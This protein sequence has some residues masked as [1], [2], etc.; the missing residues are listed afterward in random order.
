VA[1]RACLNGRSSRFRPAQPMSVVHGQKLGVNPPG[2]MANGP[3]TMHAHPS[4]VNHTSSPPFLHLQSTVS[5]TPVALLPTS[6]RPSH[7]FCQFL[8]FEAPARAR[9]ASSSPLTLSLLSLDPGGHSLHTDYQCTPAPAS[10][11]QVTR[12][13]V[14]LLALTTFNRPV[15]ITTN[16]FDRSL[17]PFC[18]SGRWSQHTPHQPIWNLHSR[19]PHYRICPLL[20]KADTSHCIFVK[21]TPG[22]A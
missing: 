18:Q 4:N 14:R 21:P 15:N 1:G 13:R 11:P 20:A 22:L 3:P 17:Y 9:K 5:R 2:R 19:L 6:A 8:L 10:L 16:S 7:S 12:V